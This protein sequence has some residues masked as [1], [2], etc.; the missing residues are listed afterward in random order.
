MELEQDIEKVEGE[1][2]NWQEIELEL[3]IKIKLGTRRSMSQISYEF[4]ENDSVEKLNKVFDILFE[5][6]IK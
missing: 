2:Y 3:G 1:E 5:E 4:I 6:A